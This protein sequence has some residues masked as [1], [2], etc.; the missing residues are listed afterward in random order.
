MDPPLDP[1]LLLS[2]IATCTDCAMQQVSKTIAIMITRGVARIL[3]KGV[4]IKVV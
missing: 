1:P 3:E 4:L 2:R